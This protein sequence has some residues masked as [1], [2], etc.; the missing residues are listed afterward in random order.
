MPISRWD[1]EC[2]AQRSDELGKL[3]CDAVNGGAPL[4]FLP[5]LDRDHAWAYWVEVSRS[6]AKGSVHLL[7]AEHGGELIGAVQ[8][9]EAERASASHRAEVTKLMVRSLFRQRGHGRQLML[10]VQALARARGRTTLVLDT[11]RGDRSERL[12]QALGW[13]KSG[14]V[15]HYARGADGALDAA[16]LYHLILG[17]EED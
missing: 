11:R 17:G 13:V 3:L 5:P 14:E 15:P 10:A 16:S 12:F 7:V 1:A 9:H 8:L 2:T 4:G 6:I